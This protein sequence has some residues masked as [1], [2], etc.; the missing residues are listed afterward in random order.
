MAVGLWRLL[1][2]SDILEV[3][4]RILPPFGWQ[5][6]FLTDLDGD[7]NDEIIVETQVA[8]WSSIFAHPKTVVIAVT[9]R[10]GKF[11]TFP[12]PLA[13]RVRAS[14]PKGRRLVGKTEKGGDVAVAELLPDG[15]WQVQILFPKAMRG[16]SLHGYDI[17]DLDGSGQDDDVVVLMGSRGERMVWFRRQPDGRWKKESEVVLPAGKGRWDSLLGITNYGVETRVWTG[18]HYFLFA[19]AFSEWEMGNRT[20]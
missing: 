10:N 11:V 9:M 15:K 20:T 16:D 17:G 8:G 6:C 12:I 1:R 3:R 19:P 4:A 18:T 2:P 5:I 13:G 14:M 7:G